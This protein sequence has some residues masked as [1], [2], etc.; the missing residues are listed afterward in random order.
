MKVR[1]YKR[2]KA[3][4]KRMVLLLLHYYVLRLKEVY[5]GMAIVMVKIFILISMLMYIFNAMEKYIGMYSYI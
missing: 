4:N 5:P 3:Y 2:H 1:Y